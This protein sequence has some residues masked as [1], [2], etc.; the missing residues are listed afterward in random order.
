MNT[1]V[2]I[3]KLISSRLRGPFYREITGSKS[4]SL[5]TI[6]FYCF[7]LCFKRRHKRKVTKFKIWQ[8][9]CVKISPIVDNHQIWQRCMVAPSFFAKVKLKMLSSLY[10]VGELVKELVIMFQRAA[11]LISNFFMLV[12]SGGLYFPIYITVYSP[13]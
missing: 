6:T 8:Q 7:C 2:D 5:F 11:N 10:Q 9:N 3:Y 13:Y 4:G 1:L 12:A